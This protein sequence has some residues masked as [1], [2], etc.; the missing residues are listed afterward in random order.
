MLTHRT[1][2][3]FHLM[4]RDNQT[5]DGEFMDLSTFFRLSHHRSQIVMAR[6]AMT[7]AMD[8]HP[9]GCLHQ[10]K[11]VS[12]MACLPSLCFVACRVFLPPAFE[13]ITR[14]W[15]AAV[16]AIFRQSPL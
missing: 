5:H 2:E 3:D 13:A 11:R 14:R 8:H 9:V 15:L 6:L 16:M 1:G 7:W 4:F 10:L 12:C